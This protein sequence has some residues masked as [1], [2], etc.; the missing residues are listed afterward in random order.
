[1]GL[2][3]HLGP[4]EPYPGRKVLAV[5]G[6]IR[7]RRKGFS[8]KVKLANRAMSELPWTWTPQFRQT[9]IPGCQLGVLTVARLGVLEF[10]I[11]QSRAGDVTT[12]A[13]RK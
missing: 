4:V 13:F 1:M 3:M 7:L 2:N 8:C 6:L 12:C 11:L 10:G 5:R 9:G